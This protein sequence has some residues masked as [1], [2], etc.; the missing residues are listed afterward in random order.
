M[1]EIKSNIHRQ[2]SDFTTPVNALLAIREKYLITLLLESSDY[3]TKENSFSFIGFEPI[4]E[5]KVEKGRF[6][7][8]HGDDYQLNLTNNQLSA[9]LESFMSQF[10]FTTKD[11]EVK[12]FN[13]LFGYTT[14][15]V[16]K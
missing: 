13:G 4:A 8:S 6:T 2:L 3:Q 1:K 5:V 15:E 9:A 7:S 14:F 16:V 10:N 12:Q 11:P